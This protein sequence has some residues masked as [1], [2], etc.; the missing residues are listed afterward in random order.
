MRSATS[1][2]HLVR[3]TL[4]HWSLGRRIT[5]GL[6]AVGALPL[7]SSAPCSAAG[8]DTASHADETRAS[9]P[10]STDQGSPATDFRLRDFLGRDWR[11]EY[12]RFPLSESGLQQARA[13]H[14]LIGPG[15]RPVAYQL[16]P[17]T[18]GQGYSLAFLADLAPLG[19]ATYAFTD[20]AAEVQ[21][22]LV[23]AQTPDRIVLSNGLTGIAIAKALRPGSGPIAGVRLNSGHWVGE[24]RFQ[25]TS[26]VTRYSAAL[27]ASGPIFAEVTCTTTLADSS[28]WEIRFRVMAGEPVVLVDE[29]CAVQGD[30]SLFRLE[31]RRDFVPDQLF[32]R[33]GVALER[34]NLAPIGAGAA[35]VLEP[36]LHWNV[37]PEQGMC[38]SL[39]EA[40]GTDVL[41]V[42]ARE[43]SAWVDPALPPDKP[44]APPSATLVNDDTGL[45]L[46]FL[47]QHGRRTWMLS[48]LG[49]EQCLQKVGETYP[50]SS[51]PFQYV[52]KHGHFPLNVVKD[53]VLTWDSGKAAYPHLLYTRADATR[54]RAQV[55]DKTRYEQAIPGYLA[56][57]NPLGQF[58]MSGPIE[59]YYA[60]ARPELGQLLVKS[61]VTAMQSAVDFLTEQEWVTYGCAP[62]H[63]QLI[64]DAVVLADTALGTGQASP[65]E[66]ERLLAQ[67][68][69]LAYAIA[70]PNYWSTARGYSANPNMTTSVNGYL[71]AA[72]CLANTHPLADAW[73]DTAMGE[74]RTEELDG[75]SDS[76]GGW[77]EAP[78]YAMVA[79]DQILGALI[80]ARNAGLNNDLYQ[81]PR[82]KLVANWFSKLST[83]PDSR[84]GGYRHLPPIGNTYLNEP[85]GEFGILAY[86][87]READ[88]EFAA[89]M[90]WMYQQ[91]RSWPVPGI[92]G[93]YPA[94]A[95]YRGLLVDAAIPA[96]APAWRSELF[97]KTGVMLRSGFP[98]ERET[99]LLLLAG[100]FDGWRS[101]WDD[102]SGSFTLWGKGRIIA[103]DFG[104]YGLAPRDDHSMVEAPGVTGPSGI[105][106]IEQF[107]TF[108]GF[109][110]VDGTRGD[111]RRQIVFIKDADPVGPNY[112]VVRDSLPKPVPAMWR[113]WL[114]AQQVILGGSDE[115]GVGSA[116][117]KTQRALAIGKEDV[118]LDAFFALPAGL[119]LTTEERTRISACGILPDGSFNRMP[120]TQIG[121]IASLPEYTV[122]MAVLY[123]RL[124]T[125]AQPTFAAIANGAGVLV[126]SPAGQ[127][128]VFLSPTPISFGEDQ[129]TFGGTVGSVVLRGG[130]ATL[131]LGAPGNISARGHALKAD[132]PESQAWNG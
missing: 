88:P 106:D 27:T 77:L 50:A 98:S 4:G 1:L 105:M 39:V 82:V 37:R 131:S 57:P 45:H 93:G 43:A 52:I 23:V 114:T 9:A 75:W 30:G 25:S 2:A 132:K 100:G 89:Q 42:G 5:I 29:T 13:G 49:R 32:Y 121:L 130:R 22:N 65:A 110:Y 86:L 11:N 6:L 83:P 127:D 72:A 87:F 51:L 117:M 28:R 95:G 3:T 48:A 99:S 108:D 7:V 68:A 101:H 38:F 94:L 56:D 15:T 122:T 116:A 12:V 71:M 21:T 119:E 10:P 59:A 69:F 74:L 54:F 60:T 67:A 109:D 91:H 115:P 47:L 40:Q 118:D 76:N 85:T 8:E 44:Q 103:D 112:Y 46:G 104:Y 14:A 96:K 97:P 78:H 33:D 70:S 73:V 125:E 102:D 129:V 113:L 80:M 124:K 120:S 128:Y 41:S 20:A 81:D 34:S 64:G 66:R 17:E 79:Y 36:W 26:P 24:S 61:A 84:F 19:I 62:H 53:W 31:L 123:P 16:V 126:E 35:F 92:G 55:T 111:W 63:A 90:Q 107:A 58:N 18:A